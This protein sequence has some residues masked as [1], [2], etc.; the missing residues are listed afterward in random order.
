MPKSK[1]KPN[2]FTIFCQEWKKKQEKLGKYYSIPEAI[3]N[4]ECNKVWKDLPEEQKKRYKTLAKNAKIDVDIDKKTGLGESLS[5]ITKAE[6]KKKE[7]ID[8]MKEYIYSITKSA[9]DNNCVQQLTFYVIHT[10]Y[11]YNRTLMNNEVEYYPAEICLARCSLQN[12]IE[13][14]YH[15]LISDVVM[16]GYRS[17]ALIH[18]KETHQIPIELPDGKNDYQEIFM[19][20]CKFLEPG[21]KNKTLPPLYTIMSKDDIYYPVKSILGKLS[22]ASGEY[23]EYLCLYAFEDLFAAMYNAV[24]EQSGNFDFESITAFREI[25]K[26]PY[27]YSHDL[28]C[29]FHKAIGAGALHCSQSIVKRWFYVL[30]DFC[31]D[32]LNIIK[33]AGVHTPIEKREL[34]PPLSRLS[35]TFSTLS[36]NDSK[37]SSTLNMSEVSNDYRMRSFGKLNHQATRRAN[38]SKA[39][40]FHIIDHSKINKKIPEVRERPLRPPYSKSTLIDD[41][42]DDDDIDDTIDTRSI[43][44]SERSF[45]SIGRGAV[46]RRKTQEKKSSAGHGYTNVLK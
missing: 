3:T 6:Q 8:N 26:D 16:K 2:A 5:E 25:K 9:K 36:L 19:N 11:A 43:D 31:C 7:F 20:L 28:E 37:Y 38:E 17:D 29:D 22:T 40:P 23:E 33:V 44:Y 46:P 27:A 12:G 32:P 39:K 24:L 18:S 21:R 14:V 41:D 34:I 1:N 42:D 35:S 4:P 13:D 30:C 10:N 45:P 15:V